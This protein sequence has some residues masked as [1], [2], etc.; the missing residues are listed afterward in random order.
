MYRVVP[1]ALVDM[2]QDIYDTIR[3]N[4]GSMDRGCAQAA[5]VPT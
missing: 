3:Y 1:S 5:E 2:I 4:M